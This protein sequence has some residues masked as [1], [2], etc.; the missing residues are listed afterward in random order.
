MLTGG[1]IQISEI[2]SIQDMLSLNADPYQITAEDNL[3]ARVRL[4]DNFIRQGSVDKEIFDL[5]T[6]KS[7]KLTD[8]LIE[9]EESLNSFE[10][11]AR[12]LFAS[13]YKKEPEAIGADELSETG[14]IN[15]QIL[16]QAFNDNHLADLREACNGSL[17][18]S[19]I[20]LGNAIPDLVSVIK[21]MAEQQKETMDKFNDINNM[22]QKMKM[23]Q[24]L[25]DRTNSPQKRERAQDLQKELQQQIQQAVQDIDPDAVKQISQDVG[26]FMSGVMEGAGRQTKQNKDDLASWGLEDTINPERIPLEEKR[27][28]IER[29]RQSKKIKEFTESVGK[30]RVLARASFKRKQPHIKIEIEGIQIGSNLS[31]ILPQELMKLANPTLKALFFKDFLEN[32]LLEY[33]KSY[34]EESGRGPIV[35]N[36]DES[37]SMLGE[38]EI[39]SKAVVVG[40]L[41]LAQLQKRDFCICSF[42]TEIV[43]E[44]E[45]KKGKVNVKDLF[46]IVESFAYG[47][48]TK[49]EPP[50]TWSMEKIKQNKIFKKADIVFITDGECMANSLFIDMFKKFKDKNEVSCFS[51][52]IG[53]YSNHGLHPISDKIVNVKNFVQ[54]NRDVSGIFDQITAAKS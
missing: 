1:R 17:L 37:G 30:M 46:D 52:M 25:A 53:D 35:C 47:G 19:G 43:K 26:Q 36:L 5:L 2:S 22:E 38:K 23:L 27:A 20:A 10:Y 18:H 3:P 15:S 49:F 31:N 16:G 48:G 24:D 29:I 50:L 54:A 11:L 41:E 28:A 8:A 4:S 33:E 12:D 6:D 9:G 7:E 40:L 45:F 44:Y 51:I 21:A 34:S 13:I 39:W 14:K 32:N 42:T